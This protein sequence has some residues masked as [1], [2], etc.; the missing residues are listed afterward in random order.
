VVGGD[1]RLA[2]REHLSEAALNEAS[3]ALA[4]RTQDPRKPAE[5]RRPDR[6]WADRA[7]A[8]KAEPPC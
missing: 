3:A 7:A 4:G 1:D 8:V 2:K 5:Y 6:P